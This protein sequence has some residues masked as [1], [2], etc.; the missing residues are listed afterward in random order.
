MAWERK[1]W[2]VLQSWVIHF[3][4][5]KGKYSVQRHHKH[6]PLLWL[7]LKYW[8]S[9][10][11]KVPERTDKLKTAVHSAAAQIYVDVNFQKVIY[12]LFL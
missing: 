12:Y 7:C 3:H 4:C 2:L 6:K 8:P 5:S 9:C 10:F 1:P 11:T